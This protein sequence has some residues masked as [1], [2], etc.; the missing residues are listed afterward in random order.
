MYNLANSW[1]SLD[2]FLKTDQ[3]ILFFYEKIHN[4]YQQ[5]SLV[6]AEKDLFSAFELC[7]SDNLK[8][9]ILGQEPYPKKRDAHG[10]A[11]S[12]NSEKIPSSLRNIY[13]S[14]KTSYPE[15]ELNHH[16]LSAWAK[17]GVLLLNTIL[18]IEEAKSSSHFNIGWERWTD[19]VLRYLNDNYDNLIVVLWGNYSKKYEQH[20]DQNKHYILSGFHPSPL[21]ARRG[22]FDYEWF[23]LINQQLEKLNKTPIDWSIK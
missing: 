8:V 19:K 15:I 10:L 22:F 5:S 11:F 1:K 17:Q 7:D 6:P 9:I 4:L 2:K 18:T 3:E 20:F 13:K 12:S 14:I 21:S 16:N 23:L